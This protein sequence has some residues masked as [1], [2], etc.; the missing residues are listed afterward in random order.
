[1][2]ETERQVVKHLDQHLQKLPAEDQKS[3]AILEQLKEDEAYHA[4]VAMKAG[5]VKFPKP[6]GWLMGQMAKVMTKTALWI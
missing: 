5:G 3:R 2:A 6:V 1:M 4:S